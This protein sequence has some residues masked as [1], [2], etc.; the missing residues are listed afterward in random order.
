[1]KLI[2][3]GLV[4]SLLLICG[5]AFGLDGKVL[6]SQDGI[7]IV[8][9][10]TAQADQKEFRINLPKINSPRVFKLSNPNRL[11]VDVADV[12]IRKN[13]TVSLEE[14]SSL[15]SLRFGVHPDKVRMVLDLQ[16]DANPDF[17]VSANGQ[18]ITLSFNAPTSNPRVAQLETSA[19]TKTETRSVQDVF[20]KTV[21]QKENLPKAT[22]NKDK[23]F[24]IA[25]SVN[26]QNLLK[27]DSSKSEE[28]SPEEIFPLSSS[29]P[30][31]IHAL[32]SEEAT[33][34]SRVS[35]KTLLEEVNN[36]LNSSSASKLKNTEKN[37]EKNTQPKAKNL[38]ISNINFTK[39]NPSKTSMIQ[40]T[41]NQKSPFTLVRTGQRAYRLTIP[42]AAFSEEHL[43]LPH[44]PP[45][46]FKGVTLV[47]PEKGNGQ[48]EFFIGVDRNIKLSSFSNDNQIL[49]KVAQSSEDSKQ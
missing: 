42:G 23:T 46:D 6:A 9:V 39:E 37:I 2:K 28:L 19:T 10:D 36:T 17:K 14:N 18:V 27:S 30:A 22:K 29:S 43:T 4:P 20:A 25:S 47:N 24:E 13:K 3:A 15:K 40:I 26:N 1:M 34:K 5:N 33:P 35:D 7:S 49:I 21:I 38:Q 44:F 45:Q 11:V 12:Q 48:V 31:K 16:E 8:A 41:L 32:E